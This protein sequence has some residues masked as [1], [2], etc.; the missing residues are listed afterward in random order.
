MAW[1]K[2][3]LTE[4]G[5]DGFL[6]F[7]D[8]PGAGVPDREGVYVVF[9]DADDLPVFLE[10]SAAGRFKGKDPSVGVARLRTEWVDG[11]GIMYV[12]RARAGKRGFTLN[13]RLDEYRRFG[14]GNPVA[15][16]GGRLIWQLAD[17]RELLVGW[18]ACA[19]PAD[20]EHDMIEEFRDMHGKLPF[21]NLRRGRRPRQN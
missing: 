11:T 10:R 15:H 5:F 8:L 9:R 7:A 18:R 19:H 17:Q 20:V 3:Q 21:A 14:A 16:W 6:P 13:K 1:T 2:N 12:G 4:I